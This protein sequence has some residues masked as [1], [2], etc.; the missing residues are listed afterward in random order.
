M[1]ARHTG[2]WRCKSI[3]FINTF[4]DSVNITISSDCASGTSAAD[5]W[6]SGWTVPV[7]WVSM[8]VIIIIIVIIVLIC[9]L[10]C[11]P[12]F[13]LCLPCCAR[14]NAKLEDRSGREGR[15]ERKTRRQSEQITGYSSEGGNTSRSSRQ[16]HC[17]HNQDYEDLDHEVGDG[18]H[19]DVPRHYA[20]QGEDMR[21]AKKKSNLV[22]KELEDRIRK[23]SGVAK[24]N[25][26]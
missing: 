8:G 20:Q 13:C 16:Y 25:Y 22:T 17:R 9:F 10:F 3:P 1:Q 21:T 15:Q 7:F 23:A 2:V 24:Q 12:W 19:Y 4:S 26:I 6:R 5:W 14:R 18:L 11:C